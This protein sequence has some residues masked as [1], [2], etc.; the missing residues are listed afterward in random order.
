MIFG[1]SIRVIRPYLARSVLT[2][3]IAF[4]NTYQFTLTASDDYSTQCV[5]FTPTSHPLPPP[6]IIKK[7]F[8]QLQKRQYCDIVYACLCNVND[9][10]TKGFQTNRLLYSYK[11]TLLCN[12]KCLDTIIEVQN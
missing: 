3:K 10:I 6:V 12:I 1:V 9:D 11:L 7:Y 8:F 2:F 4:S 5:V